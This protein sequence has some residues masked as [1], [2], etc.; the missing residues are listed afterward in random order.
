[1][2][3]SEEAAY[4]LGQKAVWISI[5]RQACRELGVDD[6]EAAKARWVVERA[7]T[8]Q[9]L[10]KYCEEHGDNQWP[11]NL[12]LADVVE[13]RLMRP[14]LSRPS[15][16]PV[17][18]LDPEQEKKWIEFL[19]R[20]PIRARK[21]LKRNRPDGDEEIKSF[22]DLVAKTPDDILQRKNTGEKTLEAIRSAL[23]KLGMKLKGDNYLPP[24]T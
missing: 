20:L 22:D 8:V 13:K 14:I 19:Y 2:S 16:E 21:S 24:E 10:R 6:P 3:E 4:V 12:H 7:E 5:L 18:P 1:M 9:M 23:F 11:D 15:N 17:K